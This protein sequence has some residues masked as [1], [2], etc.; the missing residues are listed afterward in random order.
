MISGMTMKTNHCMKILF[1][2]ASLF[3]LIVDNALAKDITTIT[4]KSNAAANQ[5]GV[6]VTFGQ[7]FAESDVPAGNT[8]QG[9]LL[10]GT[11]VIMQVDKKATHADNSLRH[12]IIS[13]KLD[14]AAG[15]SKVIVLSDAPETTPAAPITIADLPSGFSADVSLNVGGTFYKLSTADLLSKGSTKLWLSGPMVSEWIIG[16]PVSDASGNP[17]PHL[18]AYFHIRAY[19]GMN[20]I[21]VDVVIENNWTFQSA[22][23][24]FTYNAIINVGGTEKYNKVGLTQYHHTRWHKVFWWGSNPQLVATHDSTYLQKTMAVPNYQKGLIPSESFLNSMLSSVE[25]MGQGNLRTRF[26]NTGASYQIG[27]L[28]QWDA[29]YA[30]S[31]DARAL[32]S[33][34]VNASAGG[35][36]SIH[37]RDKNTGLPV[38][39]ATYPKLSENATGS[40]PA[41]S[42]GNPLQHDQAHQPSIGYLAYLVTGDYF[43]LEELLF[44]ANWNMVWTNPDYRQGEK[45]IFGVQNRGQVWSLRTLAQAAYITPDDHAMKQYLID[46]VGFNIQ[47]RNTNWLNTNNLGAIQDYDY[48]QYSPW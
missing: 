33:T 16:G 40:L 1:L 8:L 44:W 17:H 27:P 35:S 29:I 46:R 10:D 36:Y 6:P 41:T 18:A 26:G 42:G 3:I 32:A 19:Q 45:G 38:S 28:A 47:N 43:Y 11:P 34:L 48:P 12:A 21:R 20:N 22:P 7:V 37:Y 5:V 4:I 9:H 31:G 15:S 24:A 13:T 30:I 2:I 39:I 14:M 23:G 25:P